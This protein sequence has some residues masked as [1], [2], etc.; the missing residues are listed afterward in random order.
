MKSECMSKLNKLHGI[1]LKSISTESP[2]KRN[3]NSSEQDDEKLLKAVKNLLKM[4]S[5]SNWMIRCEWLWS[6]SEIDNNIQD[7]FICDLWISIIL[8]SDMLK[9]FRSNNTPPKSSKEEKYTQETLGSP[10][11]YLEINLIMN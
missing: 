4:R 9:K 7:L 6:A 1:D 2:N 5:S 8:F 3:S 11:E 10:V